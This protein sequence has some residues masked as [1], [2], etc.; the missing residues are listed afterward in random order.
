MSLLHFCQS[1]RTN[2]QLLPLLVLVLLLVGTPGCTSQS[3]PP[4]AG[5]ADP[6]SAGPVAADPAAAGAAVG[7]GS[8]GTATAWRFAERTPETGVSFTYRNG[9]E[10]GHFSILESLGGGVA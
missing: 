2:R 1:R 5:T 10:A 8:A 6:A 3:S 4:T 9:E 7:T